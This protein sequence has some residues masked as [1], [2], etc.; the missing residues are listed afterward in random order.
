MKPDKSPKISIGSW[1]Y[2]IGPYANNPIPLPEV[3]KRLSDL[4]FDGVELGG[5]KPHAHPDLY[6]SKKDREYLVKMLKENGLEVPAYA[7]DLWSLP[8]AEGDPEIVKQ[9]KQMFKRSLDFCYDCGIPAI[10]VDTVTHTPLPENLDYPTVWTRIRDMFTW[11]S[12]EAKKKNILVVWEFEPGFIINKPHEIKK[13]LEEVNRDNFKV[14]FDTCHAHMCSVVAAKQ[15]PPLD[16]LEGGEKEFAFLL[17][18]KIGH[19][20][21]IDSDN[22]LHDNETST[23]APL[24][25]GV[26]DFK[27]LLPAILEAGYTSEWWSIDLCFW[28]DAWEVTERCKNYLD[29]VF[30][31]LDWK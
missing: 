10:R 14:L 18:G 4:G 1:A 6:P 24:G 11:C 8:F 30:K 13:M 29:R 19:V 25:T 2:A 16:K 17:K 21:I 5:F 9:Y 7:A 22:T 27:T 31:E 3:I 26:L 28:P 15:T 23:H 20:H 12:D